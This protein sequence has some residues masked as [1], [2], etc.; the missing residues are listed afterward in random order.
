[1]KFVYLAGA[2]GVSGGGL[3]GVNSSSPVDTLVGGGRLVAHR[4]VRSTGYEDTPFRD[5]I[6]VQ[7]IRYLRQSIV[8]CSRRLP[9]SPNILTRLIW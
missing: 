7:R 3:V 1:M 8:G 9:R 4:K 2:G 6:S 5:G